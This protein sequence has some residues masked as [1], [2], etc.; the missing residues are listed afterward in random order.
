[1]SGSKP[2]FLTTPLCCLLFT[3]SVALGRSVPLSRPQYTLNSATIFSELLRAWMGVGGWR[4]VQKRER[5]PRLHPQGSHTCLQLRGSASPSSHG[6]SPPAVQWL[7]SWLARPMS[8]PEVLTQE[9]WGGAR[10]PACQETPWDGDVQRPQSLLDWI[11][12]SLR[13]IQKLHEENTFSQIFKKVIL[14]I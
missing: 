11:L 10:E 4:K 13:I 3:C 14:I 1:M 6:R 7:G 5:M 12:H 8:A 2:I 9:A